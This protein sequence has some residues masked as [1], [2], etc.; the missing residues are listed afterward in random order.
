[1]VVLC[2]QVPEGSM[3]AKRHGLAQRRRAM[4]FTQEAL[5]SQLDIE[6]STVVRWEGGE[7]E[8]LPWIRPK[9]A[10]TLRVSADE[11]AELLKSAVM[12]QP[13]PPQP[14][15]APDRGS[16]PDVI[17]S[18]A[19]TPSPDMPWPQVPVAPLV[20][21]P[22]SETLP[23][24]QLPPAVTDF[25]GRTAQAVQLIELLRY[26][27]N[28]VGVPVA[29]IAGLPGAGKT[30][31]ALHVAHT[32]RPEFPD[33]QLWVPLDGATGH[34]RQPGE[35]LGE[36]ARALGV[37]GSVIPT[38]TPERASLYRSLLAGRRVL[39][40]ADDAATAAQVQPLLPGTGQC[41]VLVTSR[42][43]LAGP[44]GS[45]LVSL[46]PLTPDESLQ[47][48]TKIV[49]QHRVT[50][51]PATA[52]ELAAACGQL[53]LAV[54]IAGSRLAARASWPLSTFARR[55]I[56]AR[57][58]LDELQA[59]EMSVRAS[60]TQSYHTLDEPSQRAFRRLAL[61]D[62]SEITE[63][64]VAALL[65]APD[66]A[67]VVNRLADNSLLTE[68]GI[69]PAGQP[70]YRMHDLLRDYAAEL[71]ADEPPAERDAALTRLTD[72]WL[73]LAALADARLPSEPYFSAPTA[74]HAPAMVTDPA[75][76]ELTADPV[77]W[78][79]TERLGLHAAITRCCAA[80]RYRPA[81]E[82]AASMAS[83]WHV[84]GRL[85][86]A[87]RAWQTITTVA[88]D[89]ADPAVTA[90]AR[91]RFAAAICGQ[92]RHA[93]ARPIVDQC[94]RAFE[95]LGDKSALAAA[96]YWHAS[97]DWNLGADAD[98]LASADR[99]IQ[100]AKATDDRQ[101]ESLAQRF[102][103]LAI[104]QA[105]LP[106]YT[107][108]AVASAEQALSLARELSNPSLT[109]EILH[110]VANVCNVAGRYEDALRLCQDGLDLA[111]D[112]RI[113][114]A[115]AE[116]LG[117][118]GD[119]CRGLGRYREAAE[120]LNAAVPIFRDHFMRR[121]HGLCLLKLGYTYQASG[122]HQTAVSYLTESRAIFDQLQLDHY[123]ER[124]RQ[125]LDACLD[126]Q[127]AT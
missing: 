82:L 95:K 46:D 28:R 105:K 120:S 47:L 124:V 12:P 44:P 121:H 33:G 3:A 24:S 34:P 51:D 54:R 59:G 2:W 50:A 62:A 109:H 87:E 88:Q 86:D 71:L 125:A 84:E 111:R 113:K 25:T 4:G 32:L 68:A 7:T 1:L 13:A 63:W 17:T 64:Q 20:M 94:I 16:D 45:R 115:T 122:D 9:L 89:A 8:P 58:R 36:L 48:L 85:D 38:S 15:P 91:L 123:S 53:P 42:S 23:V 61:L 97:C 40:L 106:G 5:A 103:A 69:D 100:L 21:A 92:G 22:A 41:A 52:A 83:F 37:P 6:R 26:D 43:E 80:G 49:G 60:L 66:A 119:A 31:L 27:R 29:V 57:R 10:R 101:T 73:R 98:A 75:A 14:A 104:G 79:T 72:G 126:Q 102:R 18:S 108:D 11:L 110:T 19:G 96:H 67:D 55:V 114:V 93:E 35:V 116:W 30:A 107:D 78:F 99:A 118:R 65:G 70:R 117:I 76:S 90:H 112:L 81:A 56:H 77:A 127:R 74:A 39:V